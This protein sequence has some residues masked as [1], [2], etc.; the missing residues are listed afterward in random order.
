M[1]KFEIC[2]SLAY[3]RKSAG[4]ARSLDEIFIEANRDYELCRAVDVPE[5]HEEWKKPGFP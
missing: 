4:D 3:F 1:T 5:S 2:F